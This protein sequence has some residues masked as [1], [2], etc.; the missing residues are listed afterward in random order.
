MNEW[1]NE[2]FFSLD[3][4][5]LLVLFCITQKIWEGNHSCVAVF[6]FFFFFISVRYF[7]TSSFSV[8]IVMRIS[9]N[10]SKSGE[11]KIRSNFQYLH[12]HWLAAG[13]VLV[14]RASFFSNVSLDYIVLLCAEQLLSIWIN[15]CKVNEIAQIYKQSQY[16]NI[17]FCVIGMHD[18]DR[19][20]ETDTALARKKKNHW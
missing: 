10:Y 5:F 18:R 20:I 14:R 12:E 8:S 19:E 11:K 6:F 15:I 7:E 3:I 1:M 9:K 4:L 16:C 2:R 17:F 13:S